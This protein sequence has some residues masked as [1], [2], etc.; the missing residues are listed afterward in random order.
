MSRTSKNRK[1][2]L[3]EEVIEREREA[4][5]LRRGGATYAGIATRVE[6]FGGNAGTAY[7]AVQRALKRTLQ[8]PAD[9]LRTLELER[10]DALHLAMW[11]KAMG[12]SLGAVDR[13]LRIAERRAKLLGLD[14]PIRVDGRLMDATSAEIADL[15]DQ[16]ES[17]AI[18]AAALALAE[19]QA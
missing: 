2:G 14:A 5:A 17:R 8:E 6:G 19:G 16:L 15:A 9:E 1:Q 12:G 18:E 7:R 11:T 13:V 4:L 10:L 3:D